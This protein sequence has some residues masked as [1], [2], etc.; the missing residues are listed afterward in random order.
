MKIAVIGKGNVGT[1]LAAGLQRAGHEIRFGHRDPK[2]SVQDA[3]K[4]GEVILLGPV[5]CCKRRC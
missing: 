4:W 1:A 3:A 2:G 5:Q